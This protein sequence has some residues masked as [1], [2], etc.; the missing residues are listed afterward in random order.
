M[1]DADRLRQPLNAS[2]RKETALLRLY[3]F[4]S[5]ST[6]ALII[7]FLPLYFLDSGF[8]ES[9][10]GILYSIGPLISII[11]NLVLGLLSDKYR[12]I[13]KILHLI[14]FGQLAAIAFLFSTPSFVIVCIIMFCF[15]FFQTPIN[16][17]TDS[18]I[19]LSTQ[20]TGKSYAL[21]RIYGSL[22]F[23]VTAYLFGNILKEAGSSWTLP[24]ILLTIAVTFG[25]SFGL[26]DYQGSS[27]K[28]NFSGLLKLIRKKEIVIFFVLVYLTSIPHRMNEGFLAITLRH[29]G[30]SDSLVGLA[31]LTSA[32]SE[33]PILYLL[34]KYGH[35][36][37]ELPLLMIA[38]IMYGVRL[39]FISELSSPGWVIAAQA[40]HSVTFGI[41][42]TTSLRYLTQLIPDEYRASGQAFF[43]VIWS[44]LAGVTSGVLGGYVYEQFGFV[45]F[46]RVGAVIALLAAAGYFIKYYFSRSR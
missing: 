20:Y 25:F 9:Q 19:L 1:H 10:I 15:Y 41:F 37:K 7:S 28:M 45:S 29:M 4:A 42:F 3:T 43:T 35:K 2:V 36:F 27:R 32:I 8:S 33:I 44:G 5:Y 17:L 6:T 24:L 39:L 34:G 14:L 30:A 12:T 16:S 31:W 13:K 40:M 26:K 38:A 22:G 46:F 23:A 18:L 21:I 11:S